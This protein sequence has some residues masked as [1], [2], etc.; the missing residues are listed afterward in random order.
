MSGNSRSSAEAALKALS[1]VLIERV[2]GL[3]AAQAVLNSS[4][5]RGVRRSQLANYYNPHCNQFLPIDLAA[6]LEDVVGE[7]IVTAELAR[8][9]GYVLAPVEGQAGSSLAL[10]LAELAAESADLHRAVANGLSDGHLCADDLVQI[11][12]EATH[13]VSQANDTLATV[14]AKRARQVSAA[15]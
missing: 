4:I 9:A 15:A 3:D 2:G 12:R 1:R 10:E 14:R 5:G 6:R 8:R 13:L 11:E 7:P